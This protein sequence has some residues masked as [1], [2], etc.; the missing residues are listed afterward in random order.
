MQ[1][2]ESVSALS[3]SG[4]MAWLLIAIPLATAAFLLLAG[5]MSDSWGHLLATLAPIVSFALGL[6]LFVQLLT[7]PADA[8]HLDVTRLRVDRHRRLVHRVRPAGRPAVH[9]VRAADHRRRVADPRLLDRLHGPRR[10]SPPVLRLPQPVH[11]RHADAGAGEQLPGAVPR[12]GGRRSGVVPA[13]L[14][15][16]AQALGRGRRQQGVHRQPRRRPGPEHGD[17]HHAGHVRQ[18]R[19]SP[20][21]TPGAAVAG[22]GSG[23]RCIGLLLLL[24]AAR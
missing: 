9:P 18:R 5:K 22:S 19:T 23:P 6:V 1:L 16:G 2:L 7:S 10:P 15:L 8:R 21:S 3:A 17:L 12:L 11:R 20:T 4:A 14:L 13:D 24:G